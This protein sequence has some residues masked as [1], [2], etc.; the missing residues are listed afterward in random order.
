LQE[1]QAARRP[2]P[3]L[4]SFVQSSALVLPVEFAARHFY[5]RGSTEKVR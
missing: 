4:R 5:E 1:R 3:A 2:E